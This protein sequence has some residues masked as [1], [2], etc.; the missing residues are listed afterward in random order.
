MLTIIKKNWILLLIIALAFFLRIYQLDKVPLGLSENE[1]AIGYN[2]YSIIKTGRDEEGKFLPITFRSFGDYKLPIPIYLTGISIKIN[3]LSTFSIRIVAALVGVF[4]VWLLYVLAQKLFNQPS[5]LTA[6]F[7]LAISPWH[8]QLSRSNTPITLAI[9]LLLFEIIILIIKEDSKRK[10]WLLLAIQILLLLTHPSMW[11][12]SVPLALI[13]LIRH[14]TKNKASNRFFLITL[15]LAIGLVGYLTKNTIKSY[16]FDQ[17]F[18]GEIGFS[19]R[20]DQLQGYVRNYTHSNVSARL[21]QNKI[22]VF[23]DQTTKNYLRDFDFYNLFSSNDTHERYF[24]NAFGKL[25]SIELIGFFIG[26]YFIIKKTKP[27]ANYLWAILFLSP[28]P[29]ITNITQQLGSTFFVSM[30]PFYL[31]TAYGFSQLLTKWSSN[32][33]VKLIIVFSLLLLITSATTFFHYYFVHYPI[34][35][36]ADW[37]YGYQQ[38]N[39]IATQ[40]SG[41]YDHLVISDALATK[42]YIYTLFYEK[43]DPHQY[44][45]MTKQRGGSIFISTSSFGK[46]EYRS[47]DEKKDS[48]L[49]HTLL[50]DYD[51]G[52]SAY[53]SVNQ[54]LCLRL[55]QTITLPDGTTSF[56][57]IGS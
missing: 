7:L 43:I 12:V 2:A 27:N 57:I 22:V 14:Q 21:F 19:N 1:A 44:Q 17:A 35:A 50:I 20:I 23:V 28:L 38:V 37:D 30:I 18:Y 29:G 45:Q 46:Y 13:A 3:D 34:Q 8:V 48:S 51:P 54:L 32:I 49:D 25:Y 40:E 56:K 4:S 11:V 52:K 53:C 24:A 26:C 16:Y 5:A 15:I 10:W 36:L 6:S 41:K 39:K 55:K 9:C 33:I 42:P 47:I 31:L